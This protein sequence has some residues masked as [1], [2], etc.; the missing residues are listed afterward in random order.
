MARLTRTALTP[1]FIS[2]LA[3]PVWAQQTIHVPGD[4][5][6]IQAAINAASDGDTVLVAPGTY[7]ENIDTKPRKYRHHSVH[8]CEHYG[9]WHDRESD[10]D[11]ISHAYERELFIGLINF[12]CRKCID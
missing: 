9:Q 7:V 11:R 2:L 5:A 6:T 1:L 8:E 3:V 12:E 10:P 4:A